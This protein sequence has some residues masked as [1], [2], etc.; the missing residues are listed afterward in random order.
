MSDLGKG[1]KSGVFVMCWYE[2][3]RGGIGYLP[4]GLILLSLVLVSG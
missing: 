1:K 2:T 4:R 3:R